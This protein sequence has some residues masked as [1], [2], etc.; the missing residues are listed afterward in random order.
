MSKR[1]YET[2]YAV[3]RLFYESF[4]LRILRIAGNDMAD[5]RTTIASTLRTSNTLRSSI[6]VPG[7]E[8]QTSDGV[9]TRHHNAQQ[10]RDMP[11]C[12]SIVPVKTSGPGAT[13]RLL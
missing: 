4:A 10:P 9:I 8:W 1:I 7:T 2:M 12:E 11:A 6:Q 13:F 5:T 3:V